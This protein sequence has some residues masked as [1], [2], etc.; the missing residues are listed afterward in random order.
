[1]DEILKSLSLSIKVIQMSGGW[2][3]NGRKDDNLE[4]ED[5]KKVNFSSLP[6]LSQTLLKKMIPQCGC[7]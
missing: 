4:S 6:A 1:M 7:G 3:S 2:N 5:F